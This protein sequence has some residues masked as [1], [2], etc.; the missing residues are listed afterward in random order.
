ML[1]LTEGSSEV[2][3]FSRFRGRDN[4]VSIVPIQAKKH[5]SKNLIPYCASRVHEYG[6]DFDNGDTVSVVID[7]DDRREGELRNIESQCAEKGYRLYLSNRSFECW[8]IL[9]FKKLTKSLTQDELEAT[10]SECIGRKYKKSE[11][12]NKDIEDA[13]IQSAISRAEELMKDGE[14]CNEK[15]YT[16]NP[17]TTV[18]C[19]VKRLMSGT[20]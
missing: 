10:L 2:E 14:G 16:L 7:V 11:G 9:H 15:C 8:L 17:S 12:I 3:Y 1:I 19:L 20:V 4:N 5:D 18:H 13:S 6:I